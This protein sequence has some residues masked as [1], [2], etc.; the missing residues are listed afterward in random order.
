LY[1]FLIRY[2]VGDETAKYLFTV[3]NKKNTSKIH[4]SIKEENLQCHK[5]QLDILLRI[6]LKIIKKLFT[7]LLS[8]IIITISVNGPQINQGYGF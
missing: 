5:N 6:N 8:L 3:L 4:L 1:D 2:V 7:T